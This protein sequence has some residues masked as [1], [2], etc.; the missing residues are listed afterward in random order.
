MAVF[1][2]FFII[3]PFR[4]LFKTH[5]IVKDKQ[6]ESACSAVI[7]IRPVAILA[8]GMAGKAVLVFRVEM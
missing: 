2:V 6:A 1:G 3:T 8:V 5:A 4:A 7:R